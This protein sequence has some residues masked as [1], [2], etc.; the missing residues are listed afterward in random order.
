[1]IGEPTT[2]EIV[3][4]PDEVNVWY[5][6]PSPGVVSVPPEAVIELTVAV[7]FFGMTGPGMRCLP[8]SGIR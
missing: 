4:D 1:M 3:S 8:Y 6:Y 7:A 5:L 2:A